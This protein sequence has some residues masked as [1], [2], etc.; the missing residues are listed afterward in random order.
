[1]ILLVNLNQ[2]QLTLCKTN[3]VKFC[4]KCGETF[5]RNA[6]KV[7]FTIFTAISAFLTKIHPKILRISYKNSTENFETG[8]DQNNFERT[9]QPGRY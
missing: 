4:T 8:F 1:M 6:V 3:A 2:I 9:A 5:V 7:F